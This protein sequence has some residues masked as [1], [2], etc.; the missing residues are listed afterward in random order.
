MFGGKLC[1]YVYPSWPIC[2]TVGGETNG[3]KEVEGCRRCTIVASSKV[4]RAN[5][6]HPHGAGMNGR[7]T[8]EGGQGSEREG[9]VGRRM[10]GGGGDEGDGHFVRAPTFS[11]PGPRTVGNRVGK[12][13]DDTCT[14]HTTCHCPI[15]LV[16]IGTCGRGYRDGNGARGRRAITK[17][18]HPPSTSARTSTYSAARVPREADE[19]EDTVRTRRAPDCLTDN[20]TDQSSRDVGGGWLVSDPR[21]GSAT[22]SDCS[23]GEVD[24]GWSA[25]RGGHGNGG[26]TCSTLRVDAPQLIGRWISSSPWDYLQGCAGWI[27]VF[28]AYLVTVGIP[29]VIFGDAFGYHRD[30][31]EGTDAKGWKDA[32]GRNHGKRRRRVARRPRRS[33]PSHPWTKLILQCRLVAGRRL[34]W[35][36]GH[37]GIGGRARINPAL[38]SERWTVARE[39]DLAGA[40]GGGREQPCADEQGARGDRA[41]DDGA[42]AGEHDA[43]GPDNAGRRRFSRARGGSCTRRRPWWVRALTTIAMAA[44]AKGMVPQTEQGWMRAEGTYHGPAHVGT[45]C[46]DEVVAW[47]SKPDLPTAIRYSS[48]KQTGFHGAHSAGHGVDDGGKPQDMM[49]MEAVTVN[50]TGWGPLRNFLMNTESHIVFGQ[51]HRLPAQEVPAASAWARRHGWRSVWAPAARGPRGGWSAGV[52]I[53]TRSFIGLRHP[54]VGQRV[55]SDARVVAAVIEAPS[56]RPFMAYSAYCHDGQGLSRANLDLCASI[57][58]HYELQG[59]PA[60]QYMIAADWNMSP[61]AMAQAG[62]ADAMGGGKVVCATTP[63][64]TCR[65]KTRSANYDFF[66]LSRPMAGVVDRVEALEATGIRTHAPVRV[67]FL[68]RPTSLR[69]LS[70]RPP[71]PLPLDRVYGPIPAPP[72]EWNALLATANLLCDATRNGA[73]EEAAE[74]ALS[75]LYSVWLDLAEQELLDVTGATIPKEGTRGGGP[76]VAWRSILPEKRGGGH[77]NSAAAAWA[78]AEDLVRDLS[79]VATA[80]E[81]ID[82]RIGLAAHLLVAA[83]AERPRCAAVIPAELL[84]RVESFIEDAVTMLKDGEMAVD[85]DAGEDGLRTLPRRDD[86][87]RVDGRGRGIEGAYIGWEAWKHQVDEAAEEIHSELKKQTEQEARERKQ[88]WHD[89]IREGFDAGARNAHAFSRLPAEWRPSVQK[90]VDGTITAEPTAILEGQRGKYAEMWAAGD[91]PGGYS[92]KSRQALPRLQPGDLRT[93]SMTFRR[94]TATSHDGIH[95]RHYALLSDG[96]LHVLSAILEI[97]ELLGTMP[98]QCRL[99]VTPLLEKPKGGFRP[100]CVY[101]SLYRL[102]AKARQPVATAWEARYPRQYLSAAAGNG[103]ADTAWRQAVRQEAAVSQG[104]AAASLMWDLDGFFERVDR[105]KLLQRAR[106]TDFPLPVLRLSLSMY[107]APRALTLDGRMAKELWAKEGVGAGCGLACTYVKVYS[108]PPLDRLTPRLPASTTLDLHV[109]DFVLTCEAPTAEQVVRDLHA[110][111]EALRAMIEEELGAKISLPKASLVASSLELARALREAIGELAGPIKYAAPNLGIDASAAKRRGARGTGPLRKQRLAKA[112]Q[113][114]RRLRIIASIVGDRA[115]KIYTAGVGPSASYYAAVQGMSD[116]EV[117]QLRRLSASVFP[118]RSRFRSLTIVHIA[119]GMPTAPAEVAAAMQYSRMVWTAVINGASRPRHEGFDLPGLREAW[120]RV[121]ASAGTFIDKDAADDTKRRYWGNSRGPLAAAM[122]ELDRVGWTPVGPFQWRDDEGVMVTLTETP[123]ALLKD[124]LVAAV[125]RKAERKV[126]KDRARNE[127]AFEG[128]RAC[129]DAAMDAMRRSKSMLPKEKGAFRS[130]MMN[131]VLTMSRAKDQGYEVENECPLCGEKGDDERHRVYGCSKTRETVR[132]AV[133]NWFLE[134]ALRAPPTDRFWTTGII[135]HPADIF[136][137]A[138]DDYLPWAM[139]AKGE[140]IEDPSLTGNIFIDGSCSVSAIRGLQRAAMA[141]VQLGEDATPEKVVSVPVWSTLPQTSQASEHAAYAAVTQLLCGESSVFGDCQGVLDLAAAPPRKQLEGRRKYAGIMLSTRRYPEGLSHVK[142]LIKVKAHR[143]IGSIEDPRD[144]W[145]AIGNDLADAAAKAARDRHPQPTPEQRATVD[146]YLRRVPLVVKAVGKAMALFP[147]A[148]GNLARAATGRGGAAGSKV[149]LRRREHVWRFVEGRWRCAR[150]WTYVL[151]E[152]VPASRRLQQCE[153]ARVTRAMRRSESLGHTMFYAHGDMPIAYCGRCGGWTARR[154]YHLAKP[155]SPPTVNGRA[156]LRRISMGLHPW[157]SKDKETGSECPRGRFS[158]IACAGPMN[159]DEV[160]GRPESER[161]EAHIS[162][163]S[164]SAWPS[165]V[166]LNTAETNFP[167]E[168]IETDEGMA[169]NL[170]RDQ[171][172]EMDE[173]D[174]FDH[175]GSL[176]QAEGREVDAREEDARGKVQDASRRSDAADDVVLDGDGRDP[177]VK[178]VSLGMV[179]TMLVEADRAARK[180]R[181]S[182]YGVGRWAIYNQASG[183]FVTTTVAALEAEQKILVKEFNTHAM[184]DAGQRD[185]AR[186]LDGRPSAQAGDAKRRRVDIERDAG[187]NDQDG[188]RP[189]RPE[190]NGQQGEAGTRLGTSECATTD[191]FPFATREQLRQHLR[192]AAGGTPGEVD[193]NRGRRPRGE[194]R[195]TAAVDDTV[196]GEAKRRRAGKA[197]AAVADDAGQWK[198]AGANSTSHISTGGA[199]AGLGGSHDADSTVAVAP[200]SPAGVT[201][202]VAAECGAAQLTK[203]DSAAS[204]PSGCVAPLDGIREGARA[205]GPDRTSLQMCPSRLGAGPSITG[206][207]GEPGDVNESN[208]CYAEGGGAAVSCVLASVARSGADATGPVPGL[209]QPPQRG[210]PFRTLGARNECVE[211]RRRQGASASSEDT[212]EDD[213]EGPKAEERMRAGGGGDALRAVLLAPAEP[214]RRDRLEPPGGARGSHRRG[215]LRGHRACDRHGQPGGLPFPRVQQ[216]GPAPLPRRGG[217]GRVP[218]RLGGCG[219][220]EGDAGGVKVAERGL[221]AAGG[222]PSED[223]NG[224][225]RPSLAPAEPRAG[226]QGDRPS[227]DREDSA[228][229][230]RAAGRDLDAGDGLPGDERYGD[231]RP[232]LAPAESRAGRQVDRPSEERVDSAVDVRAG[233]QRAPGVHARGKR[234]LEEI[235]VGGL[236]IHPHNV[237]AQEGDMMDL[238]AKRAAARAACVNLRDARAMHGAH[239]PSHGGGGYA[240]EPSDGDELGTAAA[241]TARRRITGKTRA[242]NASEVDGAEPQG[243]ATDLALE[244]SIRAQ[245]KRVKFNVARSYDL[246]SAPSS[247]ATSAGAARSG[248]ARVLK[249]PGSR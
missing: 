139:D 224:E 33:A 163:S 208:Q 23:G 107:A 150:C 216:G 116:R 183:H 53:F 217:A 7:R 194:Q 142:N 88:K 73:Q 178:G 156:A 219:A 133:P 87:R 185:P 188:M 162:S 141:L 121:A 19:A 196:A 55:V 159:V 175:G 102:W 212:D 165:T 101:A 180:G 28:L 63:R 89:W 181:I 65:T 138:R 205:T 115:R 109:D 47:R 245:L 151:G 170:L 189:D 149:R 99:V 6:G 131:A 39:C 84:S 86:A 42:Q 155:C 70:L 248:V 72:T 238:S 18:L 202:T 176:D 152:S 110:A 232:P 5:A 201:A 91:S 78:W 52:A 231:A 140:R 122:L 57:G 95:M 74:G 222:L 230:T 144:R 13:G 10:G 3:K 15:A 81:P 45:A 125:R 154:A 75:D 124:L 51:E 203:Q 204:P 40:Q 64:G 17:P 106:E 38:G 184:T 104:G 242:A 147:P 187:V 41:D 30:I 24:G 246:S 146:F 4:R 191:E 94:R 244:G 67:T 169:N 148:G 227:D 48:P 160:D 8:D 2:G 37:R 237:L 11:G 157:R 119:N 54:D 243:D 218:G 9:C 240:G 69:A 249:R 161:A 241:A 56:F 22:T 128:R 221:G 43:E 132:A 77:G 113:R 239:L 171:D 166:D 82:D 197:D 135:P 182:P 31:P 143:D 209:Q 111:Q 32:L 137:K 158:A 34:R 164:A 83:R 207:E 118:P 100:V 20:G 126:G 167:P 36:S 192:Y 12:G 46:E 136:P 98:R 190:A 186:D 198:H 1:V 134:E 123:P 80:D 76:R 61:E 108:V 14:R 96:A 117:L 179:A 211:H 235:T 62:L 66:L 120:E 50:S 236:P 172:D 71:P 168:D 112:W 173:M 206:H 174:V 85:D 97:C 92:W 79:R 225:A 234:K 127:S 200:S 177:R 90:L 27:L 193:G 25:G 105:N 16:S 114:R 199:I 103:P 44:S 58:E 220:D 228:V 226:R 229:D 29:T 214:P 130:V 233:V 93:S 26:P 213:Y 35:R 153:G 68:P 247:A 60:L 129:V 215:P 49:A 145:M 59:D 223:R 210:E 195:A 21:T